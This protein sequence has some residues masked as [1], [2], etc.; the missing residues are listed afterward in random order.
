VSERVASAER[1]GRAVQ[2]DDYRSQNSG[3]RFVEPLNTGSALALALT[4]STAADL[5]TLL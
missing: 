4:Q 3:A 1:F 5:E 2:T